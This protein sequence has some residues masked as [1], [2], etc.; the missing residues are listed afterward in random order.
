VLQ[1]LKRPQ[2]S[3]STWIVYGLGNPGSKYARNR[4]NVGQA[5]VREL[6]SEHEV[7]LDKHR[8]GLEIGRIKRPAGDLLLAV[9][10]GF[11]NLSGESLPSL[12]KL[13]G[14]VPAKLIVLHDELDL[15]LGTVRSKLGGGHAGHNGL[16]D[17][18]NRIGP[19]FHR[20]RI[21]IGRP[22]EPM[23]AADFV[24]ANFT[25]DES[26]SVAEAKLQAVTMVR[27]LTDSSS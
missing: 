1:L 3:K 4:H 21:G 26:V 11:M 12:L 8:S 24:L 25:A 17:I 20:I 18:I 14:G 6:A 27:E 10:R 9:S 16:R 13:E 15:P 23:S 22:P 19:D 2:T 5:L 7:K